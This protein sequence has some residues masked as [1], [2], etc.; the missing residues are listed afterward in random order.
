MD[1][2]TLEYVLFTQGLLLSFI[3]DTNKLPSIY[4]LGCSKQA[5]KADFSIQ[6]SVH[7]VSVM[8]QLK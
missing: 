4:L 6:K 7:P 2:Q 3:L 8:E 5:K 1:K